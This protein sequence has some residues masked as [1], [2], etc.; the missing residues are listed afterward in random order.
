MILP[1]P[2]P[3]VCTVLILPSLP[4]GRSSFT[5]V[6]HRTNHDELSKEVPTMRYD[7]EHPECDVYCP[8]PVKDR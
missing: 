4:W 3:H 5:R 2:T 8:Y 7:P 1:P 6:L